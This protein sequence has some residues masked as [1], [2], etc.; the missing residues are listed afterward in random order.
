MEPNEE[1]SAAAEPSPPR[2]GRG[3]LFWGLVCLLA[4]LPLLAGGAVGAAGGVNPHAHC[5]GAFFAAQAR[6]QGIIRSNF[7]LHPQGAAHALAQRIGR[8]LGG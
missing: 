8:R 2:R 7:R 4:G 5:N 3:F 1:F 6:A